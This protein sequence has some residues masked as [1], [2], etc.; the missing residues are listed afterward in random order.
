M[1]PTDEGLQ[2]LER[3]T[4]FHVEVNEQARREKVEDKAQA[5]PP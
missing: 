3:K 4:G 1:S 2:D 5:P